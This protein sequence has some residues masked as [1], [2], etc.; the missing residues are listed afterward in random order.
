MRFGKIAALA[1]AAAMLMTLVPTVSVMAERVTYT[2]VFDGVE[3]E[4]EYVT[5]NSAKVEALPAFNFLPDYTLPHIDGYVFKDYT[6]E[7]TTY[8]LTYVKNEETL[9]TWFTRNNV[10]DPSLSVKDMH[11]LGAHDAFTGKMSSVGDVAAAIT[12]DSGS[13]WA[14]Y[15]G[16]AVKSISQTQSAGTYDLLNAG[17]RYFDVRLTISDTTETYN[18]NSYPGTAGEFYTTHGLLAQPLK[19]VLYTIR[20][21][22]AENP[23]E[24][25][26][27]DFQSLFN[28][29]DS[30]GTQG[31]S[32][33]QNWTD[34]YNVLVSCGVG[35]YMVDAKTS[36][37]G[38][39]WAKMTNNGEHAAV[40]CFGQRG[41]Q[42]TQSA[43][44][45]SASSRRAAGGGDGYL[46]S[47][48]ENTPSTYDALLTTIQTQVDNLTAVWPYR[49]M[50]AM[51]EGSSI[52]S[53]AADSN[54][55]LI[56]EEK[57]EEWIKW[58]PTVMVDDAVV[59]TEEYI[60]LF[61]EIN[62]DGYDKVYSAA[63][64]GV[65]I[66]TA[67]GE[68]ANV[69]LSSVFNVESKA[70]ELSGYPSAVRYDV[71]FLQYSS[72][73]ADVEGEV[74]LE[75]PLL[76]MME[77]EYNVLLDKDGNVIAT[78]AGGNAIS[79]KVSSLGEFTVAVAN[80]LTASAKRSGDKIIVTVSEVSTASQ[81]VIATS[82]DAEGT[83][84]SAA[85]VADG[86]AE[87][88]EEGAEKV[89]VFCLESG[90]SLK[91]IYRSAEPVIE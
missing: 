11:F 51:Y 77:G 41:S 69:P 15:F 83:L 12:G 72:S 62:R 78:A 53:S 82:Y 66:S 45:I 67:A 75:F 63:S 47:Y 2:V 60:R 13:M 81:L 44:F 54:P 34:L 68:G 27:L 28:A 90:G 73:K 89:K 1:A 80:P 36:P 50:Q 43:H 33:S 91:P 21:F 35:E 46:Y 38:Q 64:N 49:I 25:I 70:V 17:V 23:G 10:S 85:F 40:V 6:L 22:C 48:Y 71:S 8:T 31:A 84:L 55:R 20:D 39:T 79:A 4:N 3:R 52:L 61:A 88:P 16:G 14:L 26:V 24:V 29:L 9:G 57:F 87:L 86:K 65:T 58:L 76:P 37:S 56:N 59:G 19:T 32:T 7:G 18:D 74:T 42:N 30:T 5:A